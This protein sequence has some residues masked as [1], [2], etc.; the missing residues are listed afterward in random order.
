MT[1]C[2]ELSAVASVRQIVNEIIHR[3]PICQRRPLLRIPWI[4]RPFPRIAQI[5]VVA[6]RDHYAPLIVVDRAPVRSFSRLPRLIRPA[7]ANPLPARHLE[8]IVQIENRVKDGVGVFQVHDGTV[9]KNF[10]HTG[11]KHSPFT[12]DVMVWF[13]R[14]PISERFRLMPPSW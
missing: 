7:A 12:E 3:D 11:E 9:W 5:H 2:D 14:V 10:S 4:V 1:R 13:L 8:A 6:D